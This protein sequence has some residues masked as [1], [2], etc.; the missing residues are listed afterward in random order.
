ML[1]VD[2]PIRLVVV[3][4]GTQSKAC[5][6]TVERL[7]LGARVDLMGTVDDGTLLK[8]YSEAL[9]VVYVPYEEDYGYVTLEA[10]QS[11][12]PVITASDSGGTLEFVEDGVNGAVCEPRPEAL[13]AAINAYAANPRRAAEHGAAGYDRARLITWDGVIER[14]VAG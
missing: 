5:A 6:A 12:K 13:A 8:L 10:F 7:D 14:L 11:R 2:P 1:H 3:G 9:A 4:E